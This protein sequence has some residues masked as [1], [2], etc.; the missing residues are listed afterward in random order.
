M[1]SSVSTIFRKKDETDGIVEQ[2]K[3]IDIEFPGYVEEAP[4]LDDF[5][6]AV[7]LCSRIIM[8][9]ESSNVA[10]LTYFPKDFSLR[11]VLFR[12]RKSFANIPNIDN[13]SPV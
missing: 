12:I 2:L 10:G 9:Y 4:S 11:S 8:K 13:E 6:R 1:G 3:L 5:D 7:K